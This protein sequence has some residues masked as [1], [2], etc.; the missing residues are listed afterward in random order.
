VSADRT[1]AEEFLASCLAG[2]RFG[3]SG[4]RV[5]IEEFLE[6]EEAT[7]M[8]VCDGER[9]VLLPA[10]RDAK[11][12]LDGDA[13]PNTGGMGAYAPHPA[14]GSG[15]EEEVA[16]R[17]VAPVLSELHARGMDYRGVLYC[18]LMLGA[19]GPRV[20]EFNCRFG[21]P[22]TQAVMPLL[23]GSLTTLLASAAAGSLAPESIARGARAAVTVA[24][25]DAGYPGAPHG[26]RIVG[27]ERAEAIARVF[28]AGTVRDA[29]G[30]RIR[31]GRA[32]YLT[33]VAL[34]LRSAR[35]AAYDGISRLGGEGWRCRSDIAASVHDVPVTTREG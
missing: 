31:G 12:A 1:E 33:G 28:H 3:A 17:V 15:L 14:V 35:R 20:V 2:G 11:R 34:D 29:E 32:C 16:R 25:T 27:L 19:A 7:V 9:F 23:E 18:G 4:H 10:A 6:G 21:D 8:V 24:I 5:L 26:G 22:E 30:W 13:G